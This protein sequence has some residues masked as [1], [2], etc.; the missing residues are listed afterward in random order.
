M[1]QVADSGAATRTFEYAFVIP[2][3]AVSGSWTVRVVAREGTENAVQHE[4]VGVFSIAVPTLSVQKTSEVVSDPVNATTNPKRIPGSVLRYSIVVT[5]TGAGA[6]DAGSLVITDPLP[7]DVELCVAPACGGRLSFTNGATPSGLTFT[8]A[9]H[10]TYSSA[11]GGG[12]PYTYGP[13][14]TPQGYDSN[15]RGIRIAPSGAM[16]GATSAGSPSFTIQFYVRVR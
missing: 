16:N 8:Y 3:N 7:I 5:N 10:V 14:A 13:S 12:P 15:I 11:V 1:T 4:G 6:I 2:S 9:S